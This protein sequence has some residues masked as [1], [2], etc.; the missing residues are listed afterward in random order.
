[1]T[2]TSQVRHSSVDDVH[3]AY[4]LDSL[5]HRLEV[6]RATNNT[7]LIALLE[8]EQKEL[9][10]RAPLSN[11]LNRLTTWW[12]GLKQEIEHAAELQV[13]Q[14]SDSTGMTWWHAYDPNSGHEVFTDSESELVQWIEQHYQGR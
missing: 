8:Q 9:M 5:A 14:E 7:Q 6:A 3:R 2:L 12:K 4:M 13:T 10:G 11:L 1:M